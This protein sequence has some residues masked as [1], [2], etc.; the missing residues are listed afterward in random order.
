MIGYRLV[1]DGGDISRITDRKPADGQVRQIIIAIHG[2]KNVVA[3]GISFEGI[4]RPGRNQVA[5]GRVPV[6]GICAAAVLDKLP[7]LGFSEG[8][9]SVIT[10]ISRLAADIPAGIADQQDK[11]WPGSLPAWRPRPWCTPGP[12]PGQDRSRPIASI[13]G[14]AA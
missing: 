12:K 11:A 9:V 10:V 5:I 2:H 13:D 7:F 8:P 14:V 4:D 3:G 6:V 1:D